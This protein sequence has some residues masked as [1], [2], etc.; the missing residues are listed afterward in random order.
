MPSSFHPAWQWWQLNYVWLR[1]FRDA[2]FHF[3]SSSSFLKHDFSFQ[4]KSKGL[5]GVSETEYKV[6]DFIP[7]T[8]WQ[9]VFTTVVP[10]PKLTISTV[11]IIW[12]E[13]SYNS[14]IGHIDSEANE[15]IL[16]KKWYIPKVWCKKV[17]MK[18]DHIATNFSPT[19]RGTVTVTPS[20]MKLCSREG[21]C[22][23]AA[24]CSL[25]IFLPQ[26]LQIFIAF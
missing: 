19:V 26:L 6:S 14:S 7:K 20:T 2:A 11:G 1:D 24:P 21:D 5:T 18:N 15:K 23:G 4:L 25:K 3:S 8:F 9:I 16:Q 13:K 22:Y 12:P 17:H 10:N